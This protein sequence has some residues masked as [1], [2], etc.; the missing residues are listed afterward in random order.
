M[1]I[2]RNLN[3]VYLPK[4]IVSP[5]VTTEKMTEQTVAM[6]LNMETNTGPLFLIAHPEKLKPIPLTA[7]A[8]VHGILCL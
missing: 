2:A 8:C 5:R 1:Q 6:G 4:L 3:K 7:P